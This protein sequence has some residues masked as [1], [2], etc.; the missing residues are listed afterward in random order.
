[1]GHMT[2]M[3]Q[4]KKQFGPTRKLYR[5][6]RKYFCC[7]SRMAYYPN[8]TIPRT[9]LS[10]DIWMRCSLYFVR[11]HK[12]Q[13]FLSFLLPTERYAKHCNFHK[14]LKI[15]SLRAV[16]QCP[17]TNSFAGRCVSNSLCTVARC[18][19]TNNM[20]WLSLLENWTFCHF[21]YKKKQ[22]HSTSFQQILS[23]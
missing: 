17:A 15:L 11:I 22:I 14:H 5:L 13:N 19:S 21:F 23:K 18:F 12:C 9:S 16:K 8:V 10:I 20:F 1:M 4:R 2:D 7:Y 6:L 3:S